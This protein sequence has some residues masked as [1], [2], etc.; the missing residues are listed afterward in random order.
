MDVHIGG[1]RV[2]G[3]TNFEVVPDLDGEDQKCDVDM[4]LDESGAKIVRVRT[5]RTWKHIIPQV[6]ICQ[7]KYIV[8][9]PHDSPKPKRNQP[10]DNTITTK[11]KRRRRI[12]L[13][14][15][16]S[17]EDD[18]APS[19]S[20]TEPDDEYSVAADDS[21]WPTLDRVQY[22]DKRA[23]R[24][25][26]MV[27]L[28]MHGQELKTYL[29]RTEFIVTEDGEVCS[30]NG[31]SNF[32]MFSYW[33]HGR[34]NYAPGK[35]REIT[36]PR[37]ELY[38]T[39]EWLKPSRDIADAL[40]NSFE[41]LVL[42]EASSLPASAF[43]ANLAH[44]AD[45]TRVRC[46]TKYY[47][48]LRSLD[49][50]FPRAKLGEWAKETGET[51]DVA[52]GADLMNMLEFYYIKPEWIWRS[53]LGEHI[54]NTYVQCAVDFGGKPN[55]LLVEKL[56]QASSL[57]IIN[58]DNIQEKTNCDACGKRDIVK[59]KVSFG[60]QTLDV[61]CVC[62]SRISYIFAIGE[63]MRALR[64]KPAFDRQD[65]RSLCTDLCELQNMYQNEQDSFHSLFSS[66]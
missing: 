50:I 38:I 59:N 12:A 43:C 47:S 65:A 52:S 44:L 53:C 61:G 34:T 29:E 64:S 30:I 45:K 15:D 2:C 60:T 3:V 27:Y 55:L 56:L 10:S 26:G 63:R 39:I 1:L 42:R 36:V 66:Q 49:R 35:P 31:A 7:S 9:S 58:N 8:K 22:K 11:S 5:P 20:R 57:D 28:D 51:R 17:E 46:M 4:S 40:T 41:D 25:N 16:E 13:R 24:R 19:P 6:H 14:T 32:A 23:P 54:W 48:T 33:E 18:H 21:A 37:G 62:L